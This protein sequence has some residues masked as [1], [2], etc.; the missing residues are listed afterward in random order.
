MSMLKL[1]HYRGDLERQQ[2]LI[3]EA[4]E[5][6]RSAAAQAIRDADP[7][8]AIKRDGPP[9]FVHAASFCLLF[10]SFAQ[11]SAS[12]SRCGSEGVLRDHAAAPR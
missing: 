12:Q 1:Y 3:S 8:W 9:V 10:D 2:S 5:V 11:R 6:E 4:M 7:R